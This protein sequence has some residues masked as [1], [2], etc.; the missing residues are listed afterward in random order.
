MG[1]F[2]WNC[3]ESG[4]SIPVDYKK[5]IVLVL[6][7][8]TVVKG[9]YNGYGSIDNVNLYEYFKPFQIDGL[10]EMDSM[11]SQLKLVIESKYTGQKYDDLELS[12][13]CPYQGYFYDGSEILPDDYVIPAD[14]FSASV[15]SLKSQL[16]SIIVKKPRKVRAK[17]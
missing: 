14:P 16:D 12:D 6:P 7:D 3:A 10:D 1:Y 13:R 11:D 2:S 9:Q 17:Q 4:A 15:E 5:N 8:D